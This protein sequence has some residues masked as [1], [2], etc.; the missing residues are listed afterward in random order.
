M[1][2]SLARPEEEHGGLIGQHG[3]CLRVQTVRGNRKKPLDV[4]VVPFKKLDFRVLVECQQRVTQ[5]E[6]RERRSLTS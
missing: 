2:L 3:L 4:P 6:E 5:T 1:D